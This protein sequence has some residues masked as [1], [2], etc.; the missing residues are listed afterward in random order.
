MA[1]DLGSEGLGEVFVDVFATSE[2]FELARDAL[3]RQSG[4]LGR[5]VVMNVMDEEVGV[6]NESGT[7]SFQA[8][9][10]R[11]KETACDETPPSHSPLRLT[12]SPG[13]HDC[14]TES[15]S[16]TVRTRGMCPAGI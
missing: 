5:V 2:L 12:M 8:C 14:V 9:I 1:E 4:V 7:Q 13:T 6:G 15:R 3:G 11:R 16:C 10:G